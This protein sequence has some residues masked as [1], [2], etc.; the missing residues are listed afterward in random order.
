MET[1]VE[2]SARLGTGAPVYRC[3]HCGDE[4]EYKTGHCRQCG[5]DAWEITFKGIE[6]RRH[7]KGATKLH[8]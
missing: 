1:T 3:Q 7:D 2:K 4:P 8:P 5:W 6:E